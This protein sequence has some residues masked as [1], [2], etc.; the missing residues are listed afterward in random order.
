MRKTKRLPPEELAP[1]VCDIRRPAFTPAPLLDWQDLFG[2]DHPVEIEVG[3]GKGTFLVY[4]ASQS[5]E[6]NF[7]GVEIEPK[8]HFYVASRLV[9]R[10]LRNA[11]ACCADAKALFAES[12]PDASVDVVH[13]YFP[14]PWWKRRHW[15]RRLFTPDF[16]ESCAQVI[17]PGGEL[18]L[19][20]DVEEYFQMMI[21]IVDAMEEFERI[22]AGELAPEVR[23]NFERKALERGGAVH[24]TRYRRRE[25]SV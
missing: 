17:R 3:F 22:D 6:R 1:F 7:F 13:V 2:N 24:R 11:R 10:E 9:R 12:V 14:D 16:A 19:A 20:T 23:T 21:G 5:P 25:I 15:K 8:Y 18:S 4:A